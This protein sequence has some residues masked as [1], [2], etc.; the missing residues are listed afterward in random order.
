[1]Q[2]YKQKNT[3]THQTNIFIDRYTDG[4]YRKEVCNMSQKTII[5]LLKTTFDVKN[6]GI[7]DVP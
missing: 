5:Y 1:M 3:L 4:Q 6:A 7:K 2:K